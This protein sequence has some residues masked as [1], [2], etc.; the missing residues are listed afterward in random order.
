[1]RVAV[2]PEWGDPVGDEL[3][4]A[5]SYV[6]I[7]VRL[8][9]GTTAGDGLQDQYGVAA[10]PQAQ[11]DSGTLPPFQWTLKRFALS[12]WAGTRAT[13]I[14]LVWVAP[15][16]SRSL[17][18]SPTAPRATGW[19]EFVGIGPA[20]RHGPDPID[21]A[22]TRRGTR[23]TMELSRGNTV[24]IA[25]HPHGSVFAVPV[26]DASRDDWIYSW[27][28]HAD[29]HGQSGLEAL[30][31]SSIP[32]PWVGERGALQVFPVARSG[33][34]G[35][36]DRRRTFRHD[37]ESA[38]PHE[39]TV[40]FDD[41]SSAAARAGRHSVEF[42]FADPA[43]ISALV[44]DQ[45]TDDGV[46]AEERDGDGRLA[47]VARVDGTSRAS[48]GA[49]ARFVWITCDA[50]VRGIRAERE[51]P[52]PRTRR[53]LELA[54]PA[55]ALRMR[56]G[57]S[58]VGVAEARSHAER[59]MPWSVSSAEIADRGRRAWEPYVTAVDFDDAS[60]EQRLSL[61]SSLARMHVYP[62]DV[63]EPLAD[64]RIVH[65]DSV[66]PRRSRDG[67]RRTSRRILDGPAVVNNGF[68]DTYR[69]VWP[70][71][72]L[73]DPEEAARLFDGMVAHGRDGGWMPR[74]SAP[75]CLDAMV[76][77][78]SDIVAANILQALPE[79]SG[80]EVAYDLAVRN[81]TVPSR[82][83][84]AG[85]RGLDRSRFR[86]WVDD[87]VAESVSWTLE[88]ASCDAAIA[89][90]ART[91]HQRDPRGPRADEFAADAVY[92]ALRAQDYVNVFDPGSGFFRGRDDRGR[93]R[94][95]FDPR[96]WGGDYTETNAWGMAFSVPHDP[97]GL[98]GLHGGRAG[99]GRAL[100]AFFSTPETAQPR[101]RGS[102]PS[103]IH[104]MIEARN[105]RMGMLGLSNQPAHHIPYVYAATDRPW[106]TQEIVSAAVRT[107]FTASDI[108]G[109]YPG[110]E[111]NGE[112]SA[113]LVLS[114]LGLYPLMPGA[115]FVLTTPV[116]ARTRLRRPI[117]DLIVEARGDPRRD[118][119]VRGVTIDGQAW[120]SPRVPAVVL[121]EARHIVFSL[122]DAPSGW[123]APT[124]DEPTPPRARWDLT[125]GSLVR[126]VPGG[127]ALVDDRGV[128]VVPLAPGR[129]CT[130]ELAQANPAA[131]YTL[132]MASPG[133]Y[134]WRVDV[135]TT[136]GG[137]CSLEVAARW[138]IADRTRAFSVPMGGAIRRFTIENRGG[139]PLPLTQLELLGAPECQR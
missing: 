98:A 30:S 21:W 132:T 126:G 91:L 131:V 18:R 104:E 80:A 127:D 111:D 100:D 68:W 129:R 36:R 57:V 92:F 54:T 62:N 130:V 32:S 40:T 44:I 70:W 56:I 33:A 110:D 83:S 4:V 9:D 74:W 138:D 113:W 20:L 84:A 133:D 89:Q 2:F 67:A 119:W 75:G 3:D 28:A 48:V 43:G 5:G 78:N 12:P 37:A 71:F 39:Y 125:R 134:R 6:G 1:M 66:N 82:R 8:A 35:R 88:G 10:S 55:V 59:E 11:G 46:I 41:G 29:E 117:G 114:S 58:Y 115:E 139:R 90:M 79:W 95:G 128:S 53:M 14:E 23:S 15:D 120:D 108:G 49:P 109:G 99:L 135:E 96:R 122:G 47:V 101:W 77:T 61:I 69:T 19:V 31:I 64:G 13:T 116:L 123:G 16:A 63:G 106:R 27:S 93:M 26:T 65:V 52:R 136:N 38:R 105:V 17:S 85:R 102:Y 22:D 121:T 51:R 103:V 107:R 97:D 112:M 94:D 137:H 124:G 60:D 34:S 73:R 42:A 81:A 72:A 50:E 118:R 24:P 87:S 25:S 45:L 76:G 86:G 7:R